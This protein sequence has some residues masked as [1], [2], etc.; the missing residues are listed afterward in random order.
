MLRKTAPEVKP[1]HPLGKFHRA[2]TH[3]TQKIPN[4]GK[5]FLKNGSQGIFCRAETVK[6]LS[7]ERTQCGG[8]VLN[9]SRR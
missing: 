5:L 3:R 4:S 6:D 1:F 2:R 9:P 8:K 7:A